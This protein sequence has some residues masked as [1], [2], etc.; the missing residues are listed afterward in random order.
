MEPQT[1][2]F[3][4]PSGSGKGTQAK[5]LKE[6]LQSNDDREQLYISTGAEFRTFRSERSD[7]YT[8]SVSQNIEDKGGLQ[9]PFLAV[10]AWTEALI[11]RF[12]GQEHLLF[13]GSPRTVPESY[14][15]KSAIEFYGLPSVHVLFV[16]VSREESLR[17]LL[18]RGRSDDTREAIENRL[19]WYE[20]EVKPSLDVYRDD[21]QF[22]FHDIDG[23]QSIEAV[24]DE[25]VAAL[26]LKTTTEQ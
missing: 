21:E 10:W 7:T 19:S 23:E 12:T 26:S 11:D 18:E 3:A 1:F 24:H 14:A 9:P 5:K 8:A 22:R 17:R 15:L 4:G 13:D 20:S 16:D 6:Y 2:I 25:I